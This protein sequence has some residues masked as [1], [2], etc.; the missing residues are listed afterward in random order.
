M[1]KA[2]ELCISPASLPPLLQTPQLPSCPPAAPRT[3]A[4]RRCPPRC[5][6]PAGAR[7]E[8]LPRLRTHTTPEAQE[9]PS[10]DVRDDF[11]RT[12]RNDALCRQKKNTQCAAKR[13]SSTVGDPAVCQHVN[14][15]AGGWVPCSIPSEQTKHDD[16]LNE[17]EITHA[18]TRGQTSVWGHGKATQ[19]V[20]NLQETGDCSPRSKTGN[21]WL[22]HPSPIHQPQLAVNVRFG[23][24]CAV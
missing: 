7:P 18:R 6:C 24:C 11:S 9:I 4:V 2:S 10:N 15:P 12:R 21:G 19:R 8:S 17:R 14:T 23:G 22:H 13:K 16:N 1:P 20:V 5:P 3:A